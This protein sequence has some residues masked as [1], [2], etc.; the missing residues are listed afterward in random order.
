MMPSQYQ[1][2]VP[3]LEIL[4]KMGGK[5]PAQEVYKAITKLF[6]Q[7]TENDLSEALPSGGNK[8]TNRI[9]WVRQSLVAKGEVASAGYG[10][11]AITAKGI[12]RLGAAKG[13]SASAEVGPAVPGDGPA[14]NGGSSQTADQ[15]PSDAVDVA[16]NL[17]DIADEYAS[18][19]KKKVLNKLLDLSPAQFEEFAGQVSSGA[20]GRDHRHAV[21]RTHR[22]VPRSAGAAGLWSFAL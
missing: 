8:W 6:P 19:F 3:L 11:W 7:L 2:E 1:M 17:E 10:V 22:R 13:K 21:R 15:K 14:A 20:T 9:Q 12:E 18:S 16:T 5:A 4:H